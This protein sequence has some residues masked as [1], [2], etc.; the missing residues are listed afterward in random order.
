M[1][2]DDD[3]RASVDAKKQAPD[4]AAKV[5]ADE[6]LKADAKAAADAKDLEG[7]VKMSKGDQ[8]LYVHPTC[9][10]DH[11]KAEWEVC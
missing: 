11:E 9:V 8:V 2:E 7:L 10:K 1:A 6:K 3:K 5:V 4:V